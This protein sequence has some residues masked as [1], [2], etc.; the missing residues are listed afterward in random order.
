MST[1]PTRLADDVLSG[2]GAKTLGEVLFDR[3]LVVFEKPFSVTLGN[4]TT[5]S[6][7]FAVL[8]TKQIY[9]PSSVEAGDKMK[10]DLYIGN[11]TGGGEMTARISET[12]VP[13]N[14]PDTTTH[15]GAGATWVVAEITIAAGWPGTVREFEIQGKTNGTGTGSVDGRL[16]VGAFRFEAT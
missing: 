4:L 7:T 16:V 3:D 11:T 2:D 13:T 1:W 12:G 5:T 9:I 6:S 14:G 10:A 15:S 8:A